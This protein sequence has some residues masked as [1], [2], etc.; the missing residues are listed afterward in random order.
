MK[1]IGMMKLRQA[2]CMLGLL[3]LVGSCSHRAQPSPWLSEALASHRKADAELDR[4]DLDAARQS[5]VGLVDRASSGG[6]SPV[7]ERVIRQ[8]ALFRLAELELAG[9]SPDAALIWGE[10]GL[11]LGDGGDLITANLYLSSGRALERLGRDPEAAA[12]YQ[13]ALAINERLLDSALDGPA[14]GSK[15]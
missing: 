8:D 7:D 6:L 3:A 5:L 15:P 12:S 11:A 4:G 10:R 1:G 9:G 14:E 2:I 13:R